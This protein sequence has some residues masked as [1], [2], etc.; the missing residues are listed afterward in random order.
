[1]L[2]ADLTSGD[3]PDQLMVAAVI[4]CTA[5]SLPSFP[6]FS[7]SYSKLASRGCV[8]AVQPWRHTHEA[9]PTCVRQLF[10]SLTQHR[11]PAQ[12]NAT[13]TDVPNTQSAVNNKAPL[14]C[15]SVSLE[16]RPVA[17]CFGWGSPPWQQLRCS[18]G[19]I[20]V[21]SYRRPS[22]KFHLCVSSSQP[23]SPPEPRA[24]LHLLSFEHPELRLLACIFP[25]VDAV[26]SKRSEVQV[27]SRE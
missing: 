7:L 4:G 22:P 8:R 16:S 3:R 25:P 13:K 5:V 17:S 19:F 15:C 11:S 26:E 2:D 9:R 24:A 1:M 14:T 23:G 6:R 12:D 18:F 27:I 20:P 10:H 21:A